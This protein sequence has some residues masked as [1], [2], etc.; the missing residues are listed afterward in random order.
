MK[1]ESKPG[2]KHTPPS[3]GIIETAGRV[4][5]DTPVGSGN[6]HKLREANYGQGFRQATF[7]EILDL[8]HQSY[9]NQGN[10][11]ADNVVDATRNFWLSG[12]TAIRYTPEHVI[13]Q[14]IPEVRD[15]IIVMD[16]K[17]LTSKLSK[18]SRMGVRFSDDG[19][20]RA[21]P[22]GFGTEWQ[23]S[24]QIRTNSFPIAL[25]GNLEA[26]EILA[27]IQD[28]IGK[29]GYVWAL[30]KGTNNEIRVPVLG[31]DGDGLFLNGDFWGEFFD[32]SRHSFGVRQ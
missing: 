11:G 31:E 25:T 17:N 32:G 22:Y 24:E 30:D 19:T 9:L 15:G 27:Q 18:N 7:G 5:T 1:T 2:F 23:N 29:R 13:V 16:E 6:F 8:A 26:S 10:K 4:Y 3:F 12:N 28:K 21:I 20:I 14:D